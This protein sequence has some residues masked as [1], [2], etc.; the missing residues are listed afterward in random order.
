MNTKYNPDLPG[1]DFR[2]LVLPG[3]TP[4]ASVRHV[5]RPAL[6]DCP[7]DGDAVV[8]ARRAFDL[9]FQVT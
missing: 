2:G 1:W 3:A 8:G 5:P 9:C 6:R 4:A 7:A